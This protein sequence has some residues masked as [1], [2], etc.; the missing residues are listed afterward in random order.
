MTRASPGVSGEGGHEVRDDPAEFRALVL[1]EEVSGAF[2]HGVSLGHRARRGSPE[3]G[4]PPLRRRITVGEGGE[5]R[6]V[7]GAECVEGASVLPGA[8]AP[9]RQSH[10]E[11]Q[12]A[13]AGAERLVG[14]RGVVGV[15]HIGRNLRARRSLDEEARVELR[16]LLSHAL[17]VQ[18]RG[19]DGD[20]AVTHGV[21]G[22]RQRAGQRGVGRV[23]RG[24]GRHH[25]GEPLGLL[26][27]GAEAD[28]PAPVLHHER[29]AGEADRS[30]EVQEPS[31]VAA[32]RIG[33]AMA[34]LV[35]A[36]EADEIRGDRPEA[37]RRELRDDRPVEIRP[38]GLSVEQQHRMS[39]L[40]PRIDVVQAEIRPHGDVVGLEWVVG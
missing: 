24:V 37:P 21:T 22:P 1:L 29:D 7:E 35:R 33:G 14:I 10:E 39:A 30:E 9:R 4:V 28:G 15:E 27:Q 23:E 5:K 32:H 8:L 18:Q 36:T 34:R 19:L 16:Q 13:G 26:G 40:G 38:G 6:T 3:H 2:D 12:L 17:I 20:P 11:G 25:A 31:R